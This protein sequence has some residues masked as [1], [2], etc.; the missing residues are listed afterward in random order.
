MPIVTGLATTV[1][2]VIFGLIW[3][4]IGRGFNHLGNWIVD[5]QTIGAGVYGVVNRLL[6]PIGLHHLPN[7]LLWFQFGTYKATRTATS[8]GS[9]PVTRTPV[10]S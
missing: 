7:T 8:T 3:P 9:S 6:L 2:G 4:Y 5:N 1:L 10:A